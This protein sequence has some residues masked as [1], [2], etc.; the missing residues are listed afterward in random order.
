MQGRSLAALLNGDLDG[1]GCG[2]PSLIKFAEF[3]ETD[4]VFMTQF[5][6]SCLAKIYGHVQLEEDH[7]SVEEMKKLISKHE[8]LQQLALLPNTYKDQSKTLTMLEWRLPLIESVKLIGDFV[9]PFDSLAMVKY[10]KRL[11]LVLRKYPYMDFFKVAAVLRG[12]QVATF[13]GNPKIF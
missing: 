1:E 7:Q 8:L 5:I 6:N 10:K 11:D 12:D 4:N 13:Q 3:P 9:K 2:K